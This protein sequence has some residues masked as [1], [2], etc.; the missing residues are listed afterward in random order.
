MAVVI[1]KGLW[2]FAHR[3]TARDADGNR[4]LARERRNFLRCCERSERLWLAGYN[5]FSPVAHTVAIANNS[6][7][8]LMNM[9]H[10]WWCDV[11]NEVIDRCRWDG[12]ILAP[13]WEES[14][15]CC[16]ERRRFE[17][18]GLPV[19]LYEDIVNGD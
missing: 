19:L 2:Y 1:D 14:V 16:E 15:G 12:I 13:G 11:D 4:N 10:Q 6:T 7:G 18:L 8:Q 17:R 9:T 3:C 5:I